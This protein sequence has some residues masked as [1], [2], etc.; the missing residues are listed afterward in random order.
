MDEVVEAY[1]AHNDV[2]QKKGPNADVLH[3]LDCTLLT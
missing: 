3:T 2:C 1:G